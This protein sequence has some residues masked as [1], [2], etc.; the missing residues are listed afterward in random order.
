MS[1]RFRSRKLNSRNQ[2]DVEEFCT[3]LLEEADSIKRINFYRGSTGSLLAKRSLLAIHAT[4]LCAVGFL[5]RNGY[6]GLPHYESQTTTQKWAM[7]ASFA[8]V[9]TEEQQKVISNVCSERKVVTPLRNESFASDGDDVSWTICMTINSGFYDFFHNWYIHYQKLDLKLDLVLFAE[10]SVAYERL[11]N[12][13]FLDNNYTIVVDA[14]KA[15]PPLSIATRSKL[16]ADE[17]SSSS[18]SSDEDPS[19]SSDTAWSAWN[20]GVFAIHTHQYKELISNRPTRLLQV[21]CSGRNVLYI[22][23]DTVLR[24]SPLSVINKN[25]LEGVDVSIAI[26]QTGTKAYA[27]TYDLCTGFIAIKAKSETI[28]FLSEW[29]KRCHDDGRVHNDQVAF[30]LVYEAMWKNWDES[31]STSRITLDIL[32]DTMFPNGKQYFTLYNETQRKEA[33]LVHANW[34]VGGANKRL[35]FMK[36]GLWEPA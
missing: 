18:S 30:N 23:T 13:P 31:S 5:S 8:E 36:H 20:E 7:P 11:S 15:A 19:N 27:Y 10:D 9:S 33:I 16:T 22:D 6:I 3:D 35:I 29:E 17:S 34:I 28:D 32:P 25:F 12:A 21:L 2:H 26:D 1:D 24:K 4:L 14:T